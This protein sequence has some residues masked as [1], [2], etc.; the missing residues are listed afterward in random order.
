MSPFHTIHIHKNNMNFN[1]ALGAKYSATR[2]LL[3]N[4]ALRKDES[5]SKQ[6]ALLK[7]IL[8]GDWQLSIT[9]YQKIATIC[10]NRVKLNLIVYFYCIIITESWAFQKLRSLQYPCTDSIQNN[11][12]ALTTKLISNLSHEFSSNLISFEFKIWDYDKL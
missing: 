5:A 1:S 12:V 3:F 2:S 11:F 9:Q 8:T 4:A 6:Y 10:F 7:W